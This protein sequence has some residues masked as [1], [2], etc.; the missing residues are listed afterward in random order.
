VVVAGCD[1]TVVLQ[2]ANEALDAVAERVKAV[3][4][5]GLDPTVPLRRYLGLRAAVAG[6]LADG[7]AVVAAVA[8]RTPGSLSRSSIRSA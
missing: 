5:R 1:T 4:D 2:A 6:I 8:S 7:V 3:V